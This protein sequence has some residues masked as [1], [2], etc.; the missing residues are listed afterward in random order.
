MHDQRIQSSWVQVWLAAVTVFYGSHRF[1]FVSLSVEAMITQSD[2]P[3]FCELRVLQPVSGN[4]TEELPLQKY[5]PEIRLRQGSAKCCDIFVVGAT[6]C[7]KSRLLPDVF[8]ESCEY[9]RVPV[10]L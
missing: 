4:D 6:G 8:A 2:V 9:S 5:I 7:G 10:I 1:V 3:S